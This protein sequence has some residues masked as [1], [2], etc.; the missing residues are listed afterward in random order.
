MLVCELLVGFLWMELR[1]GSLGSALMVAA[2][3]PSFCVSDTGSR[4]GQVHPMNWMIHCLTLTP[5][6][7][8]GM[9]LLLLPLKVA[10]PDALLKATWLVNGVA[11]GRAKTTID[12]T[13]CCIVDLRSCSES[14]CSFAFPRLEYERRTQRSR[15]TCKWQ[16]FG[17]QAVGGPCL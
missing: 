13:P 6:N 17:T 15:C 8:W 5:T 10:R 2:L 7:P 9:V 14:P 3:P 4:A 1:L 16:P 12:R 11:N